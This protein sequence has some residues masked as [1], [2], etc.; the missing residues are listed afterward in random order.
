MRAASDFYCSPEAEADY[1]T[2]LT[3]VARREEALNLKRN[4]LGFYEFS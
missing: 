2:A 3:S 1:D 4:W